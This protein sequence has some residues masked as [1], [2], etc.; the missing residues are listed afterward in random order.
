M[1]ICFASQSLSEPTVE[2]AIILPLRS[3]TVLIG[4]SA[5]TIAEMLR[6]GPANCATPIA[7]PPFEA[8]AMPGPLPRPKS[9][10]PATSA[11]C[12]LASPPRLAL[13]TSRPSLPK[14]PCSMPIS[15]GRKVQA[16]PCALPT[17][18]ASLARAAVVVNEQE[19]AKAIA[20]NFLL[21]MPGLVRGI[22]V[23]RQKKKDVD[24]RDE[25]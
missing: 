9:T 22:H 18:T 16:V 6:G 24:R 12:T 20:R 25:P 17:C 5:S 10:L 23:L 14:M 8:S 15:T 1:A 4:E 11:C 2:T 21:V 7:A 19:I 3:A 13:S